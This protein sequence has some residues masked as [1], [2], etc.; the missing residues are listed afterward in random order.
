MPKGLLEEKGTSWKTLLLLSHP[1]VSTWPS[2][3]SA[4]PSPCITRAYPEPSES[5]Q[6]GWKL[7]LNFALNGA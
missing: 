5:K 6:R 1:L 3:P 4:S 7:E 2:P